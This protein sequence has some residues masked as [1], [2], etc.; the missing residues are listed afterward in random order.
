[1]N[2]NDA[3]IRV[4]AWFRPAVWKSAYTDEIEG[5]RML[6]ARELKNAYAAGLEDAMD[7]SDSEIHERIRSLE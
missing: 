1:M 2:F 3:I 4:F 6:I 7:M 5:F